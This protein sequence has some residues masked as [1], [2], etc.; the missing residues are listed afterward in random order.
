MKSLIPFTQARRERLFQQGLRRLQGN[1]HALAQIHRTDGTISY[2]PVDWVEE[3][4]CWETTNGEERR[5][6]TRGAGGKPADYQGQQIVTVYSPNAGVMS[7]EWSV[8]ATALENGDVRYVDDG[9]HELTKISEE[10]VDGEEVLVG[11][12]PGTDGTQG[13]VEDVLL[14]LPDD[15][16]GYA[17]SLR[18][19]SEYDPAPVDEEDARQAVENARLSE[20]AGANGA[21]Q[22]MIGVAIGFGLFAAVIILFWLLGQIGGGSGLPLIL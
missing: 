13:V 3:E 4:Q 10:T 20:K 5:Y 14:D 9:G 21:K 16:D 7:E 6:Y 12:Y 22:L 11:E 1:A 15:Y 18:S 19:A 8:T 17:F 2:E